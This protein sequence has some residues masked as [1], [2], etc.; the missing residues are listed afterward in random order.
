MM[1]SVS[2]AHQSY[3][4]RDVGPGTILITER[5]L[6]GSHWA[7]FSPHGIAGEP[8]LTHT[9]DHG[10]DF[11]FAYTVN[12]GSGFEIRA[13]V[14]LPVAKFRLVEAAQL[15]ATAPLPAD[16]AADPVDAEMSFDVGAATTS[17]RGVMRWRKSA[18]VVP[19]VEDPD[20][21]RICDNAA[22]LLRIKE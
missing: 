16:P 19:R 12:G 8:V 5:P 2:L 11:L 17:G 10:G 9:L 14:G 1:Y 15:K 3:R 21:L 20:L 7:R 6:P 22:D 18:P 13:R 4:D